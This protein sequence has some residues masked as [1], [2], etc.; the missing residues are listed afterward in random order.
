LSAQQELTNHQFAVVRSD[1]ADEHEAATAVQEAATPA[2]PDTATSKAEAEPQVAVVPQ[3]QPNVTAPVSPVQ[4]ATYS[5][6]V[7]PQRSRPE[8]PTTYQAPWPQHTQSVQPTTYSSPWPQH[9]QPVWS[10]RHRQQ[11]TVPQFLVV[12]QQNL[13]A[14]FR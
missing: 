6:S 9:T 4:Q 3:S 2:R 8:Q 11:P 14:L 13:R 1:V 10:A 12:I 7:W 5:S